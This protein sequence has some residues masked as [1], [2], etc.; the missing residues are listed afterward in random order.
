MTTD[1][2]LTAAQ[3]AAGLDEVRS[4]PGDSGTVEMVVAR[5]SAGLREVLAEGR[6]DLEVG[7]VGDDWQHRPSSR[8]E[9]GGP[10]PDMQL[11]VVNS[12]FVT[13]LAG[14]DATRAA[15][16]GDQLHLDLDIS[17]A[18]CPPGTRIEVGGAVIEVTDQPHRGCLKFRQRYGS[19]ALQ[20]VNTDEGMAMRL[21]GCNARVVTPGVVRPGDVARR[22]PDAT[23]Q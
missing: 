13:L 15:L 20:A 8:S 18:N 12:R 17:V 11:N 9:D 14:G 21:R 5:P 6:L 10:H 2:H 16:A 22:L 3:I 4:S 7:L 1:H 23:G 19:P